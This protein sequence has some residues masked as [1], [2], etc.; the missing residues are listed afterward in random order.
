MSLA[1]T[2]S[3]LEC[4]TVIRLIDGLG[5][6]VGR[7]QADRVLVVGRAGLGEV[8]LEALQRA[9][10]ICERCGRSFWWWRHTEFHVRCL[11]C[12]TPDFA[13][14]EATL[15]QAQGFIERAAQTCQR[16]D[17][18]WARTIVDFA[19]ASG[20]RYW[21]PTQKLAFS[22]AVPTLLDVWHKQQG[23]R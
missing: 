5:V 3:F 10:V 21:H 12:E 14:R 22:A 13:W 7:L 11:V 16:A 15:Q 17:L 18:G 23:T 6:V 19:L 9:P 20:G 8:S 2:A 4:A 1:S